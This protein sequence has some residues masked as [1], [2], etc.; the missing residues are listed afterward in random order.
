MEEI[1]RVR[2][3][4]RG[5][6]AGTKYNGLAWVVATDQSNAP[7]MYTQTRNALVEIDRV[8]AELGTSREAADQR[9]RLRSRKSS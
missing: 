7:D 3:E 4:A 2:G 5:R 9:D 1:I 6:N 8:L